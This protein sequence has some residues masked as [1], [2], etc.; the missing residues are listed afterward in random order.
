MAKRVERQSKK[1]HASEFGGCPLKNQSKTRKSISREAGH[2]MD[3]NREL[4]EMEEEARKMGCIPRKQA[5]TRS[6][7]T[8]LHT[9]PNSYTNIS[10][11]TR[12]NSIEKVDTLG[13]KE[14]SKRERANSSPGSINDEE[15]VKKAKDATGPIDPSKN[16]FNKGQSSE[17]ENRIRSFIKLCEEVLLAT[18]RFQSG[19]VQFNREEQ[20]VVKLSMHQ[21]KQEFMWLAYEVGKAEE[22]ERLYK[23]ELANITSHMQEEQKHRQEMLEEIKKMN[24]KI[25]LLSKGGQITTQAMHSNQAQKTSGNI[26]SVATDAE[27]NQPGGWSMIT[28]KTRKTGNG[29][30]G[31]EG[32]LTRPNPA[33]TNK[34]KLSI[35]K[36]YAETTKTSNGNGWRTPRT[37][38]LETVIYM[39]K[40]T[41][42]EFTWN[43]VKDKISAKDIPEGIG[44]VSK[45]RDGAVV[46]RA[47]TTEQKE[48]IEKKLKEDP[49][50]KIIAP[51]T[52]KPKVTITGIR[53]GYD[54][55]TF[56]KIFL[57][58][59]EDL[60]TNFKTSWDNELKLVTRTTCRNPAKENWTFE[61]EREMAQFLIKK[62][63][64]YFDLM[65][66]YA[67]E[68]IDVAICFVCS[69][70]GHVAKYCKGNKIC[71]K[72]G[73]NHEG[74][75][76]S[77]GK[78]L[79]CPNCRVKGLLP[80]CHSA[81]DR[82]CPIYMDQIAKYKRIQGTGKAPERESE[83][84]HGDSMHRTTETTTGHDV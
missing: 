19:K 72:C 29:Q 81:R 25:E 33:A 61:M 44:S 56:K 83:R 76:C 23:E 46:L 41:N 70:F 47:K 51:M 55:I 28:N 5:L 53:K 42:P 67:Q 79:D 16:L 24:I 50:L 66:V 36:T 8:I 84:R 34:P 20:N 10:N 22:K 77:E 52:T 62:E 3:Q 31:N 1:D 80:R 39:D 38:Q 4:S 32:A 26:N 78:V 9:P 40:E 65:V 45:R 49:N 54:E 12:T 27:S 48:V 11:N 63:K 43:K 58:E 7:P 13:N 82:N 60:R 74:K 17:C 18:N 6:P 2:N 57:E 37:P 15:R 21:I 64:F 68:H 30:I 73:D 75:D 71:H 69:K 14:R 35:T 59:N